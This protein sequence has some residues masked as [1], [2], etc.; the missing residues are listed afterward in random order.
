M[1]ALA[2]LFV[3]GTASAGGFALNEF[4][5]SAVGRGNAVAATDTDPSSI[6]YNVGGMAAREGTGITI[7]GALV[8]PFATFH[9]A[10]DVDIDSTTNPQVVPSAFVTTRLN[11]RLSVGLGFYTP[12]G[13]TIDWP[14]NAPTNDIAKTTSLRSYFITPAI[15]YVLAPGLTIGGG[16]DIVP[17]TVELTQYV[18]FG[19]DHGTAHLGGT[20]LGFGGRIGVM[21]RPCPM[22]NLSFGAMW[23]SNVKEDFSGTGDFDAPAPYRSQLPPDGDISTKLTLPRQ[24]IVGAAYRPVRDFEIEANAMW[25]NWSSFD[26]LVV[27]VPTTTITTPEHYQNTFSARVG[28]EYRM[29]NAGFAVRA[30]YIYDPSPIKAEYLTVQLP[31]IDRHDVTAGVSKAFGPIDFHVGLLY[32]IPGT[33]ASTATDKGTFDVSAFVASVSI[34]GRF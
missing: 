27:T 28:L 34:G 3:T 29:P 6:F 1:K 21:W 17:A 8:A 33:R 22:P 32:V 14:D 18:F 23:R 10:D 13:L 7:G 20:A 9:R 11:D 26:Q 25:T 31:D 15:G 24:V 2:L 19:D 12:F 5:A 16:V 4:D 30:G